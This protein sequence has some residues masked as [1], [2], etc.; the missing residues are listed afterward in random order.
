HARR[1]AQNR[2]AGH[3][4]EKRR[5]TVRT[6]GTVLRDRS[7]MELSEPAR[8]TRIDN[9]ANRGSYDS[10]QQSHRLCY[11]SRRDR[12]DRLE[13]TA[14]MAPLRSGAGG[15]GAAGAKFAD[16]ISLL[17]SGQRIGSQARNRGKSSDSGQ[18]RG[19]SS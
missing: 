13:R 12:I 1:A 15:N 17:L 7:T 5:A 9:R 19:Q 18:G 14:K 4:G 8:P 2:P 16:K 6:L 11:R 3:T 10:D